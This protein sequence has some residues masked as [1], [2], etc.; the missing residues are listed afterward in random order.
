M[1][2]FAVLVALCILGT[3]C[4]YYDDNG[5]H[6]TENLRGLFGAGDWED[7][8]QVVRKVNNTY[9]FTDEM[10]R[11]LER[12]VIPELC[13]MTSDKIN[14]HNSYLLDRQCLKEFENVGSKCRQ[15][16][17]KLAHYAKDEFP[18]ILYTL[19]D[20]DSGL[21]SLK[22]GAEFLEKELSA[23]FKELDMCTCGKKFLKAATKCAPYY[24]TN[25]LFE[26]NSEDPMPIALTQLILRN[27]DAE[28]AGKFATLLLDHLCEKT[29]SGTCVNSIAKVAGRVGQLWENSFVYDIHDFISKARNGADEEVLN[30]IMKKCDTLFYIATNVDP[31]YADGYDEHFNE[32][33]KYTKA[34]F[35]DEYCQEKRGTFYP[36]CMKDLLRDKKMWN[37]LHEVIESAV[38]IATVTEE[39]WY[40]NIVPSFY[41]PEYRPDQEYEEW[42]QEGGKRIRK[43]ILRWIDAAKTCREGEVQCID[44]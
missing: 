24:F 8:R 19:F 4:A 11:I 38:R 34:F 9:V 26:S 18:R 15:F 30:D 44:F 25:A 29:S 40:D 10:N 17:C 1:K 20:K 31:D 28:A 5:N 32:L 41:V 42:I 7:F 22:E 35:C 14:I 36:C 12:L 21:G 2:V 39:I 3:A 13:E 33:A 16:K 23:L 37:N 27:I 43:A 6:V